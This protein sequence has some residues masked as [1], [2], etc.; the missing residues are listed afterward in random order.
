M[1][2]DEIAAYNYDG[3]IEDLKA[4]G[5][6]LMM[7]LVKPTEARGPVAWWLCAMYCMPRCITTSAR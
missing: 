3:A 6:H 1:E 4:M 2:A 5:A 7:L